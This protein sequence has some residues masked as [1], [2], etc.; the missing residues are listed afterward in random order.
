MILE[1]YQVMPFIRKIFNDFIVEKD[2]NIINYFLEYNKDIDQHMLYF[3]TLENVDHIT[4]K[5]ITDYITSKAN[6]N[7]NINLDFMGAYLFGKSAKD[8]REEDKKQNIIEDYLDNK[9]VENIEK[10]LYLGAAVYLLS[11]IKD[12]TE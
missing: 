5:Q 3:D 10:I 11:I 4:V 6:V 1:K 2:L 9:G 8:L 7:S 12:F